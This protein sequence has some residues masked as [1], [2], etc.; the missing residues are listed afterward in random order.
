LPSARYVA[1]VPLGDD[2]HS[3]SAIPR[4]V[5]AH[6]PPGAAPSLPLQRDRGLDPRR[7]G[8]G[9]RVLGRPP[10]ADGALRGRRRAAPRYARP[11][12]P[13]GG[14][15]AGADGARPRAARPRFEA[16]GDAVDAGPSRRR[17]GRRTWPAPPGPRQPVGRR[18]R[19]RLVFGV[20]RP[21]PP[22]R[23]P[24][25]ISVPAAALLDRRRACER[26]AGARIARRARR[27]VLRSVLV[28]ERA[29]PPR[30]SPR[31]QRERPCVARELADSRRR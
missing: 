23:G 2:G 5:V 12:L 16:R 15:G 25:H 4:P 24:A 28:E 8:D 9:S 3:T 26:G 13:R 18:R 19:G 30:A 20:A 29:A 17:G 14:T 31:E 22:P 10:P 7:T 21:A 6:R 1:R 27:L 11:G